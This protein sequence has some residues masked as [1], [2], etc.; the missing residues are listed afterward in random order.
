MLDKS[1]KYLI[2][3]FILLLVQFIANLLI[4]V[5]NIV[6]PSPILGIIILTIC[7]QFKIIKSEWI[8]DICDLLLKNMPLLFVPLFVGII[9]YYGLIEKNLLPIL[10]NVF[11]TATITLI[12]TA[13]FVD[14]VIKYIRFSKIKRNQND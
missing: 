8:K 12:V 4:K 6:F 2:G 5:T 14:N 7:L 3:F 13:F 1:L 11:V 10:I 9:A